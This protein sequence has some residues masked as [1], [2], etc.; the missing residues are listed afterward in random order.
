MTRKEISELLV[1]WGMSTRQGFILELVRRIEADKREAAREILNELNR[2]RTEQIAWYETNEDK[3]FE[4]GAK[5]RILELMA[6]GYKLGELSSKHSLAAE[7]EKPCPCNCH[8][9]ISN[10][11]PDLLNP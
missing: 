2:W 10:P 1:A 4:E 9:S 8:P 5:Q 11:Y 6:L 3:S 7:T